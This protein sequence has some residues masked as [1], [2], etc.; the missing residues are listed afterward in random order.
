MTEPRG[1]LDHRQLK[2][3]KGIGKTPGDLFSSE[4]D[5]IVVNLLSGVITLTQD[6]WTPQIAPVKN[7]GVWSESP[8][9]DGRQLL[10]AA[11]GNVTEKMTVIISDSSY[12]GTMKA[13]AGLSQ[14]ALDCRNFW[15]TEVQI[16]P[17]YITWWAGCGAG[18]QYALLYNIELAPEYLDSPTPS[19]QV[20]MTLER[21]PYWQPIP[22]GANPKQWYYEGT[23]DQNYDTNKANLSTGTDH[24]AIATINNHLE[25]SA[26]NVLRG[27]PNYIDIPASMIPGDAPA[28]VMLN[29]ESTTL[30]AFSNYFI[31]LSTKPTTMIDRTTGASRSRGLT[32]NATDSSLDTDATTAADAGAVRDNAN[33]LER[34]EVSFATATDTRRILWTGNV[35]TTSPMGSS[36]TRGRYAA[37]LRCRQ[38]AVT[39]GDIKMHLEYGSSGSLEPL[40]TNEV[41]PTIQAGAG[42]TTSWPITYM[43][44]IETPTYDRSAQDMSGNGIAYKDAYK[45]FT[46]ALW[47]R[48][49]AGASLLYICDL[50]LIPLDEGIVQLIQYDGTPQRVC[51]DNTGYYR[52][53]G[54]EDLLVAVGTTTGA[55]LQNSEVLGSPIMLK[56]GVNNRLHFLAYA[57]DVSLTQSTLTVRVD[58]VPRWSAMRTE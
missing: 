1:W 10:A 3:I 42:A 14:I 39:A 5:P 4:P 51:Y 33:N 48:R 54:D 8:I 21:Q 55:V 12:L 13:L 56:P 34:V 24:I 28:L 40:Q 15:Q 6:G 58:I 53:G 36:L 19:I 49:T 22:P 20:S 38:T 18:L 27:S 16:D 26:R 7:G 35:L 30:N 9:S 44:I 11:V 43:G 29:I 45:D 2:I 32:F 52:H 50:I 23:L 47:A 17:V 25:W 37:F 41:S 57:S 31:G 46:I